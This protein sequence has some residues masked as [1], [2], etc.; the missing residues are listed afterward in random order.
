MF[1]QTTKK[2]LAAV[3]AGTAIASSLGASVAGARPIDTLCVPPPF[4]SIAASAKDDYARLR[5]ACA[6]PAAQPVAAKSST[7]DGFDAPSAG[8]GAA[9]G[10]GIVIVLLAAGGLARGLSRPSGLR[11]FAGPNTMPARGRRPR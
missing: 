11:R 2:A 10:A 8:I 1:P 9:A 3:L 5:A 4:L 7:S 6:S